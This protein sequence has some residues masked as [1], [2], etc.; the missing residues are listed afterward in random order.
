MYG[1]MPMLGAKQV[2][3]GYAAAGGVD[4]DGTGE[5][6]NRSLSSALTGSSDSKEGTISVWVRPADTT[7][8]QVV[9]DI[10]NRV[11]LQI[12]DGGE[13]RFI[14]H[15]GVAQEVIITSTAEVINT[16]VWNHIFVSFNTASGSE[17][18][19]LYH[20][21]SSIAHSETVTTDSTIDFNRSGAFNFNIAASNAGASLYQGCIGELFI[22]TSF[23]DPSVGADL[24]RF[25]SSNKPGSDLSSETG[26]ICYYNTAYVDP[27]VDQINANNVDIQG[28]P[29]ASCGTAIEVGQ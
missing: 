20:N 13:I 9:F 28:G 1:L 19:E 7:G 8:A 27:W 11:I 24:A 18:G 12:L 10:G 5:Y 4:F 2:A 22:G 3:G 21:G 14:G 29:A 15:N 23:V 16:N 17:V 6:Y 26:G 25:I